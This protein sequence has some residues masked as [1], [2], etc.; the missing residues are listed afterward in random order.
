MFLYLVPVEAPRE[1]EGLVTEMA[2]VLLLHLLVLRLTIDHLHKHSRC[3]RG[4]VGKRKRAN[5]I[6][7]DPLEL[8]LE[9]VLASDDVH[10]TQGD[11]RV[12]HARHV[13]H[14]FLSRGT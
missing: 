3:K 4:E 9:L 5:L 7:L 2:L 8:L 14:P 11:P 1:C 13:D 10:Q 12:Q 6:S